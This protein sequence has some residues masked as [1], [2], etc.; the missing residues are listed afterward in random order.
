M[1]SESGGISAS[2]NSISTPNV[3]RDL[4]DASDILGEFAYLFVCLLGFEMYFCV[5][6]KEK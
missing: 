5:N 6:G 4:E 2:R 1:Q 3:K